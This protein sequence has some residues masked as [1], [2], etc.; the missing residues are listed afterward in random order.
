MYKIKKN[1]APDSV[2]VHLPK[3]HTTMEIF[4]VDELARYLKL[5][6]VTVYKYL[7][8]GVL[9]GFRVGGSWR[10]RKETIDDWIRRQEE[11]ALEEVEERAGP[12]PGISLP[13]SSHC[14]L[15]GR[16]LEAGGGGGNCE[17]EGCLE[18]ICPR[19][20]TILGRRRC[21][22]HRNP[23]LG[24]RNATDSGNGTRGTSGGPPPKD[25]LDVD[26]AKFRETN[27]LER[28]ESVVKQIKALAGTDP[29]LKL[30]VR[31]LLGRRTT[32][33]QRVGLLRLPECRVDP[34]DLDQR[35][36]LNRSVAFELKKDA[37]KLLGDEGP[38][39]I[40]A[41]VWIRLESLLTQGF[42]YGPITDLELMA[43][44]GSVV[45]QSK[46]DG[47][48]RI[49][50]WYS[51][52]GWT[53]EA[54]SLVKP[55]SATPVSAIASAY[56]S[57]LLIGPDIHQLYFNPQDAR[58]RIFAPM[59]AGELPGETRARCVRALKERMT[60]LRHITVAEASEA[61]GASE[62]LMREAMRALAVEDPDYEVKEIQDV[63]L[64]LMRRN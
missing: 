64:T 42:D 40:E 39:M 29:N 52:T 33:D 15:C 7:R 14:S 47:R 62:S 19:C 5:K 59:F 24:T 35:Y 4:D 10:F 31:S 57:F 23:I 50:G 25:A 20:W 58:A 41:R 36:P 54:L 17:E 9:P 2:E 43:A 49:V 46:R 6:P 48:L 28:F 34:T 11:S 38:F 12:S 37:R 30:P 32:S 44:L 63:G 45:D 56:A 61:V 26:L 8:K 13:A 51:P 3:G 18:E 22:H 53:P 55:E 27:F 21:V 16:T 1:K 60:G